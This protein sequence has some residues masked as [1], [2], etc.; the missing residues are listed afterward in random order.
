VNW[1]WSWLLTAVGVFGIYLTTRKLW[2]GFA[3]GLTAQ[4][5]W[6][7]YAIATRQWGF[8]ASAA[9]YGTVHFIGLRKWRA[10]R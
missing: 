9:A 7:A 1:W 5:L 4:V 6:I 10:E 8:I 3:V 2:A